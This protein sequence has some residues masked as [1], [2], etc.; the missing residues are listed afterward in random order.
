M[1]KRQL[2]AGH[3]ILKRAGSNA[4]SLELEKH[5][6]ELVRRVTMATTFG[7]NPRL[8]RT[9]MTLLNQ[10]FHAARLGQRASILA[11]A[12]WVVR[13]LEAGISTV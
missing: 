2:R 1:P 5:R 13:L 11:S 6:Q 10:H 9:A 4:R 12:E 3:K 8:C 7:A